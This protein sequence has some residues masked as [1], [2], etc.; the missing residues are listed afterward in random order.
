MAG[1]D[2]SGGAG[3]Q[4]DLKT[5]AALGVSGRSVIAALTAQNS[6][7]VSE[8]FDVPPQTVLAQMD[9]VFD[10]TP[11]LAVKTGM[12]GDAQVVLALADSLKVRRAKNLVVDPVFRSTSGKTLLSK[13]GVAAMIEHLLPQAVLVTPNLKEAEVLSEMRIKSS[14]DRVK[15]ARAILKKGP[16]AV[17]I[18]GGHGKGDPVD[19]FCEEGRVHELV[20]ERIGGK[21]SVHGTGC[22]L[23]AAIAAHLAQGD[24]LLEAVTRAKQFIN[25]AIVFSECSGKG[26]PFANPMASLYRE[27]ERFDALNRVCASIERLKGNDIGRLVPE[28]QSNIGYGLKLALN[29][30]DVVGFPGRITKIGNEIA[31]P[32]PPCFGG[33]RHVADIVLTAMNFDREKR[34]VM[35]IK[36]E[37]RLIQIC[38]KLKLSI[39]SFDRADEPKKVKTKEGSSL[40]WGTASAIEAMGKVPDIIYD[41]GGFG[42]E[43]MIRVIA[44]DMESL[45][46]LILKIGKLYNAK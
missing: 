10:D 17:L 35:N 13:E 32:A 44:N 39:G 42:K 18:T 21:V 14:A 7:G 36:Y 2:P 46:D 19:T 24:D 15:A 40:E 43:E 9:S 41:I 25:V 27:M 20:S 11:P 16:K 30:D 5:F 26:A 22:V 33:S 28:V 23:S 37:P 12:L 45:T 4:S 38:K 34:A 29:R 3:I 1:S 6:L 8:T 31:V